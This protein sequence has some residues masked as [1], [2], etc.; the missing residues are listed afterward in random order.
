[1]TARDGERDVAGF[2]RT[3]AAFR[4][5]L[6][7]V[8]RHYNAFI[9]NEELDDLLDQLSDLLDSGLLNL[10][11]DHTGQDQLQPDQGTARHAH[12]RALVP[13]GR[14]TR[15]PPARQPR[16][17]RGPALAAS[18]RRP[19]ARRPGRLQLDQRPLHRERHRGQGGRGHGQRV[20]DRGRHRQRP[21]GEQM[22]STR[23][24][25]AA[26]L[27]DNRDDEL[28]TTPARREIL[29]E[30]LYRELTKGTYPP[31]SASS[32][33]TGSSG[34]ST[35]RSRPTS[36]ATSSTSGSAST[37]PRSRTGQV[38]AEDG[39]ES[40]PTRVRELN[41]ELIEVLT[42]PAEPPQ[43]AG[44]ERG[45]A[46]AAERAR[47]GRTAERAS[48]QS[49]A[50]SRTPSPRRRQRACQAR[51][52][53]A[54]DGRV[55]RS[56]EPVGDVRRSPDAVRPRGR[57]RVR[58]AARHRA[59][60]VRQAARGLVRPEPA[61]ARS[62]PTRTSRS[63][64]RPAPARRR[65]PRRSSPISAKQGLPALILD[66]K[67]DYSDAVFVEA[68]GFH[69]YDASFD[70]MPFNPL[71]PPVDRARP[72]QPLDHI[73]QVTDII[74]RI[75]RLGDQQAF[76]L[77]EAIKR[78]YEDAGISLRPAPLDPG[79]PFPPFGPSSKQLV[80]DKANEPLLG[81]LSPIFDLGLFA[82]DA[83]ETDF[84][85]FLGSRAVI[86]LG[87]LPGDEVKNSVAEF[88]LMALY[89]YLIRQTQTHTLGRL[90]VLDEAW[91]VV[92]SP[93]L[94]PP[95]REGRAFGLGVVIATQFPRDLP[96]AVRGSTATRLFFSPGP[97]RADPR[98][99]AHHRRQ[100][101]RPRG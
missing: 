33:P 43:E 100:D 40:V 49:T 16:Q 96:E 53:G 19:A 41:E 47:P 81:R 30:H 20:Q 21:R 27:A 23:R 62:C 82:T 46:A 9:R 54:A 73:Y 79:K 101:V 6:R 78:A 80:E 39:E 3:T 71:T 88:F 13:Q 93:F 29:R 25:L 52:A 91:R 87:Q 8:V 56:G 90:L 85:E 61:R 50:P 75:Y 38:V 28:I 26:V 77:R 60:H 89:N 12:R 97:R 70:P 94:I 45:R 24:L 67:D 48:R 14:A 58:G 10:R 4:R 2:A 51:G 65:R 86:R 92:E 99:P 7:D 95:M 35:A 44:P 42:P 69:V 72:S 66:F 68:E 76:R 74:K 63:P 64:A 17:R 36:A 37:P 32:G 59:G 57:H 15:Q 31:T 84:E 18:Q 11:P 34:C 98:D 55:G 22:L 1:M 83:Q 5:P